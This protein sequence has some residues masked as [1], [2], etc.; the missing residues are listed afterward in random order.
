MLLLNV[1]CN[2]NVLHIKKSF[3][4]RPDLL[5]RD[6]LHTSWGGGTLLSSN[7]GHGLGVST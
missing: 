7:L 2:N 1:T 3:W 6:G 5:K 4:G